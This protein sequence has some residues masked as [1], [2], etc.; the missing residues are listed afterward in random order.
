MLDTRQYFNDLYPIIAKRFELEV[1]EGNK[2]INT[3]IDVVDNEKIDYRM[4][5]MGGFGGIP[6]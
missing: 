5:G 6:K 1:D 3:L 2:L 4:D